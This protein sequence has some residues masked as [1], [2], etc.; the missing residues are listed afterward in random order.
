MTLTKFIMDFVQLHNYNKKGVTVAQNAKPK[1]EYAK[2]IVVKVVYL[3]TAIVLPSLITD[4]AWWQ[5]V[6]G[7]IIVHLTAGLIMSLIFNMAHLVEGAE[8]PLPDENLHIE[9]VWV[10][11]QLQT[12]ANFARHNRLLNW[13]VGGLNFQVEHHLF[14]K[15]SHIHYPAISK[16][17]KQ[18]CEEFNVPYI[19]YPRM[20]QAVASHVNFLK[21]M[22]RA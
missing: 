13:F 20:Y 21:Q 8:Q 4:F 22:G 12:T 5:I 2:M 17:V 3:F 16:I 1:R 15:I 19:E 14:P 10:I 9:N 7:F 11:H 6:L 18:A